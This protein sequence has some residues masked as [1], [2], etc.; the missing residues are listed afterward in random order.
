MACGLTKVWFAADDVRE[1]VHKT[2]VLHLYGVSHG[3]IVARAHVR[4]LPPDVLPQ[5]SATRQLC[6]PLH[7]S[8]VYVINVSKRNRKNENYV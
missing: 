5:L 3:T 8:N 2:D 1:L 6:L 4:L 7:Q